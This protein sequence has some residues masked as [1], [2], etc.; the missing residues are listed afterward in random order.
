MDRWAKLFESNGR[1]VLITKDCDDDDN[2]QLSITIRMEDAD[3]SVGPVF[4]GENGYE[5]LDMVFELA[6]Q[7]MADNFTEKLIGCDTAMEAYKKL[8]GTE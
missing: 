4:N 8:T 2:P 5:S 1:Q 7:S 6:D 3:V